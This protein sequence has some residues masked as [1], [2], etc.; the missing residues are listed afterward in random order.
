MSENF[1]SSVRKAPNDSAAWNF[2][3]KTIYPRVF[4]I[5][6][7]KT[8]GNTVLSEEVTQGAIERFLKYRAY[9]KLASDAESVAYLA[10]SAVR[11]MTDDCRKRAPLV[12]ISDDE[13]EDSA[14]HDNLI[15]TLVLDRMSLDLKGDDQQLFALIRQG[16][17]IRE[18][19]EILDIE[20]S[21]AGVRIHRIKAFLKNIADSM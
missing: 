19:A 8:H 18:I 20:Y 16:Y 1:T 17:L 14:N 4:Y 12:P 7:R 11:L 6:F 15:N 21:A 3:F 9:E 5:I 13:V 10:R 2:W